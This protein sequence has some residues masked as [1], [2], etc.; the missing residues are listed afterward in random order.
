MCAQDSVTSP[1]TAES[2][3]RHVAS[4]S[5]A[6]SSNTPTQNTRRGRRK[7]N[8]PSGQENVNTT[9]ASGESSEAPT[10]RRQRKP[11]AKKPDNSEEH[12]S[13]GQTSKHAEATNNSKPNNQSSA[14]DSA[15]VKHSPRFNKNRPQ[16]RLTTSSS[17]EQ[18]KP[19]QNRPRRGPK[20]VAPNRDDHSTSNLDLRLL[21]GSIP[22]VMRTK[23]GK[24]IPARHINQQN[25]DILALSWLPTHSN[26]VLN[27]ASEPDN[28]LILVYYR[29]I[30]DLA[31]RARLLVLS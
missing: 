25:G 6:T 18:K 11:K 4:T 2:Q 13:T 27:Y 29:V 9:K 5:E 19:R 3:P 24:Q 28:V 26:S 12:K 8:Q 10:Q 30:Q 23:M 14:T 16:G 7:P 20:A 31:R 17:D 21:L 22:F 1:A 15:A